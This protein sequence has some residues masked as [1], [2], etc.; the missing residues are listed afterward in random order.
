MSR[1]AGEILLERG[2][3]CAGSNRNRAWRVRSALRLPTAN[4]CAGRGA[5]RTAD[6][7]PRTGSRVARRKLRAARRKPRAEVAWPAL[8]A[9]AIL[10]LALLGYRLLQ[11]ARASMVL[12]KD[13][14]T[15]ELETFWKPFLA[16]HAPLILTYQSRLFLLA[17]PTNLMVRNYRTNSMDD[18][19]QSSALR[20]FQQRMG[21]TNFV[22]TQNYVDFEALNSVFLLMR[23]VGRRERMTATST[24]GCPVFPA[25]G[26]GITL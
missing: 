6:R 23:T 7:H 12:Q 10:L 1:G 17:P 2:V 11:P 13:G 24:R 16:D 8:T 9:A 5:D 3:R 26:Q 19:P 15:P 18:V 21:V 25:R 22:E 14:W 20:A 4:E